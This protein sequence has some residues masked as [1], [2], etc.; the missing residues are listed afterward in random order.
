MVS[1]SLD[2]VADRNKYIIMCSTPPKVHGN[3]S[4]T[5]K[6]LLQRWWWRWWPARTL[7]LGS[8]S[9]ADDDTTGVVGAGRNR[10]GCSASSAPTA[11]PSRAGAKGRQQGTPFARLPPICLRLLPQPDLQ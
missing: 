2:G 6:A 7:G 1:S 3:L 5:R 8:L 10:R 9:V 4:R 11:R